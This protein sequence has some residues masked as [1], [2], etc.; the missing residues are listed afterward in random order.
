MIFISKKFGFHSC[1]VLW[2]IKVTFVRLLWWSP[3]A[4]FKPYILLFQI[5]FVIGHSIRCYAGP[6]QKPVVLHR[7]NVHR[8]QAATTQVCKSFSSIRLSCNVKSFLPV[9][10]HKRCSFDGTWEGLT[11]NDTSRGAT[12]Y[13]NYKDCLVPEVRDLFDKLDTGGSDAGK[14]NNFR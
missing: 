8:Y 2:G 3:R 10:V 13:T 1:F 7:N 11:P 9:I 12:G 6:Q 5:Y 14:V 4:S